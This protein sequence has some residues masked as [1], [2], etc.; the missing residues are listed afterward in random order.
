MRHHG[1]GWLTIAVAVLVLGAAGCASSS[2]TTTSTVSGGAPGTGSAST[3]TSTT[4]T[5]GGVPRGGPSALSVSP[6]SGSAHSVIHFS[7]TSPGDTTD[8]RTQLSQSLS[9]I[10]PHGSDCVG[11]HAQA[12]PVAP[13]GQAVDVSV[14]PDQLGGAWCPGTYAA[15]VEV[16][17]RPKCGEGMMCP[18]FIRVVAVLGPATFKISR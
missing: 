10:G 15:R 8:A 6:T 5:S 7:F 17:A 16:L 3:S 14:G 12:V 9:V 2:N 4:S 11:M 1:P 13:A 18:Q